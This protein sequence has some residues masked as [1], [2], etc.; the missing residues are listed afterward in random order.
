MLFSR[1]PNIEKLKQKRDVPRL[2]KALDHKD[3]F[4]RER[5]ANALQE[6]GTSIAGP[7]ISTAFYARGKQVRKEA[8]LTLQRLD[9]L[10]TSSLNLFGALEVERR[11]MLVSPYP[12]EVAGFLKR[13]MVAGIDIVPALIAHLE[14][15][16]VS[17]RWW[18]AGVL[19]EIEEARAVKPLTSTLKDESDEVREASAKAL[20]RIGGPE[21]ERALEQNAIN[22]DSR[23]EGFQ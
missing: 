22:Q 23:A 10:D 6:L 7:L 20:S 1:P 3:P 12:H 4:V 19:G 18:A 9:D 5:A 16:D 11:N 13:L 14:D 8:L 2:L 17:L 15:E 21:A